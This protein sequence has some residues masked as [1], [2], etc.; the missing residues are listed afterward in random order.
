MPNMDGINIAMVSPQQQSFLIWYYHSN[1]HA[2]YG[3][4]ITSH[5]QYGITIATVI[6][7]MI[8]PQQQSCPIWYHHSNS[9][10]Q[11]GITIASHAQYGITIA[12]VMPNMVSPQQQSC[13]IW[14][15]HSNSHAKYGITIATVMP[16][17]VHLNTIIVTHLVQDLI[18]IFLTSPPF[19][20]DPLSSIR[21]SVCIECIFVDHSVPGG[22]LLNMD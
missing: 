16:S 13:P 5:A 2:Q 17:I 8:L 15:H 3:I 22:Y 11:Y 19:L 9:H 10:A 7:N 18:N 21:P 6:P 14:Y 20:N 4:T 12:T 1:S